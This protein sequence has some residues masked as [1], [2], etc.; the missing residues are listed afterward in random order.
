[1]SLLVQVAESV[2]LDVIFWSVQVLYLISCTVS[3]ECDA[4]LVVALVL[5]C[6][7]D[8]STKRNLGKKKNPE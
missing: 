6:Q 8:A 3:I 7:G 5:A 1:M 2:R 4:H